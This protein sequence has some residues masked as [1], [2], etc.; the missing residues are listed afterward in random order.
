MQKVLF[1]SDNL[2]EN[3]EK[4]IREIL[5]KHFHNA[6][7]NWSQTIASE[8]SI[9]YSRFSRWENFWVP[10]EELDEEIKDYDREY[11]DA[12]IDEIKETFVKPET[13]KEP[14]EKIKEKI[15]DAFNDLEEND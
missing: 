4:E 6:W 11:A 8:E 12:V 7:E 1:W 15:D 14:V 2:M 3:L 9:T 13:R 10:Y 5:A